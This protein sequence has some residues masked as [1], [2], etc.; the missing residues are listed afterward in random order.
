MLLIGAEETLTLN[1][2]INRGLI[3]TELQQYTF[4][5]EVSLPVHVKMKSADF[6]VNK[7][8]LQ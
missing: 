2:Y 8:I 6:A 1:T 5:L 4:A 3:Y 7:F